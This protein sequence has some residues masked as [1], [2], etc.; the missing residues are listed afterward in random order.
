MTS[1]NFSWES[2][3]FRAGIL[4][5]VEEF[6]CFL[7]DGP[8]HIRQ[9][10]NHFS[11]WCGISMQTV[12]R[13]AEGAG[14]ILRDQAGEYRLSPTGVALA[15]Q[16]APTLALREMVMQLTFAL[17]PSWMRLAMRGRAAVLNYAPAEVIQ[18]LSE[19]GLAEAID[20][21][22]VAWWDRFSG[23]ERGD[24]DQKRLEEGRRGERLSY[25]YECLR[26]GFE[27]RWVALENSA[28]GYDLLSVVSRT[29]RTPMVI[30][31]KTT[32]QAWS[33]GRFWLTCNE[34]SI[35]S[36][37]DHAKLHLWGV[38]AEDLLFS[39]VAPSLLLAHIPVNQGAGQW[40]TLSVGFANTA[41]EPTAVSRMTD[42]IVAEGTQCS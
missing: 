24:E 11:E 33:T 29:D 23:V 7:R 14:W 15:C 22:T 6:L 20:P 18:C 16:S 12:L 13:V 31:V 32:M 35:L 39:S 42:L 10:R 38:A 19:S 36:R 5:R 3:A 26:T 4:Y 1:G 25:E 2:S 40:E 27:P 37:A 30:E 21:T 9:T 17:K 41:I 8:L 34:W 28:A